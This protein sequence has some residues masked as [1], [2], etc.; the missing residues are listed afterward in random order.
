MVIVAVTL[1]RMPAGAIAP[2]KPLLKK[3]TTKTL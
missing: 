3:T 1:M 2:V